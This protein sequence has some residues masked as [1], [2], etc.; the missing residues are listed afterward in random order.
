MPVAEPRIRAVRTAPG[1]EEVLGA[2]GEAARERG[3]ETYLVGGF[4]RDRLLGR[5]LGKDIDL[6]S[7]GEG[8]MDV[9]A[10]VAARFGWSRP[11]LFERFG[12]GQV[13]GDGWIL[14]VVRARSESYD[15]ES[16]RPEVRPGSLE[17]DIWRRDFTVN[18]LCQTLEGRVVDPTGRGLAD[19]RTGVLRTPLDPERTFSE[20]PLR[21]L[22]AARFVAELGFHL[23]EG[24]A[25]AMRDQA[26]RTAILSAERISGE[27]RR[28]LV[29]A[30]PRAGVETLRD[31]GLLDA[32]LPEVAAM[33][34]VEQSGYHRWDVFEHTVRALD[35]S[36]ADL[37]TRAG[38][39]LHDVGK[40]PT[41]AVAPDGRHTFHGHPAVG[42]R[43]AEQV[44][45]RLRFSNDEVHDVATLVR[46]HLRP[47]QYEASRF[48]DAAV[49][50]LIRDAGPLREPLLDVARADTRASAFP[51][52]DAIDEL[53]E[54]ME[55]LDRGGLVSRR[56]PALGGDAIMAIAGRGPGRWVG[57]VVRAMEQA[58]L[59][60]ELPAG[61]AVA[62]QA[63]LRAHPDLFD[64]AAEAE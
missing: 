5:P 11:Q 18:A 6:L 39:L 3:V 44:L 58:I 17:D 15:P 54:R 55:Q 7:V 14:E 29:A 45:T 1:L 52:T 56:V 2:V 16:R 4:V 38:V 26:H 9:L 51:G 13:R 63:W 59:D 31:G 62:A 37:V 53:G 60:G 27:L 64:V 61:D 41:H 33:Q 21:M 50:R 34:G 19:L 32:V 46:L 35:L 36:P 8:G 22:R 42:A 49:R 40:P 24:L 23:A 12:T 28:L 47:I 30:H 57:E 48:S 43:L 20:D 10:G 25:Q